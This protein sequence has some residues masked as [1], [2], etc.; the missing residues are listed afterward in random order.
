MARLAVGTLSDAF[1][2]PGLP[3]G[4]PN[5]AAQLMARA[6]AV[7]AIIAV[8]QSSEVGAG[9]DAELFPLLRAV[10]QARMVAVD[11]A[12]RELVR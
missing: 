6:D 8:T 2:L 10:R 1:G 7:A 12:M 11:Y 5:R 9:L 3:V 4:V